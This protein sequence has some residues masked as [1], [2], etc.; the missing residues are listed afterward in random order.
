VLLKLGRDDCRRYIRLKSSPRDLLLPEDVLGM[1]ASA[2]LQLFL[3]AE[4][5]DLRII[6]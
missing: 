5:Y 6:L 1:E 3:P 2:N 4:Q